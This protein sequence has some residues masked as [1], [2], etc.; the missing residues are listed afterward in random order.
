MSESYRT[1]CSDTE[2]ATRY[3]QQYALEEQ[4]QKAQA[5]DLATQCAPGAADINVALGL[6]P[7][8]CD[9][10]HW[11]GRRGLYDSRQRG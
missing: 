10:G 3:R 9:T 2:R 5:V 6:S 11:L 8:H 7:V 4:E 1:A